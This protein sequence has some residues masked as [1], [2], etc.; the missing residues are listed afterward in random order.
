MCDHT[1]HEKGGQNEPDINQPVL[2]VSML[3]VSI[4]YNKALAIFFVWHSC[5]QTDYFKQALGIMYI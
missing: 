1:L 3:Y 5:S 4:N 2:V